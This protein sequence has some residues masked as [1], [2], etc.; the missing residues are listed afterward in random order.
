MV[1]YNDGS[2]RSNGGVLFYMDMG[3]GVYADVSGGNYWTYTSNQPTYWIGS[4]KLYGTNDD[5]AGF[6]EAQRIDPNYQG[7][8]FICHLTTKYG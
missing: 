7:Y 4:G 8:T 3:V 1:N 2:L 5:P 6:T